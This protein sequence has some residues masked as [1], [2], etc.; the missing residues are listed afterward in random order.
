MARKN[1]ISKREL[2]I[3]KR[4]RAVREQNHLTKVGMADALGIN[5]LRYNNYEYGKVPLPY[6]VAQQLCKQFRVGQC[7]L[8]TGE[9]EM[10]AGVFYDPGV[11][12]SSR[13]PFS[14]AC[15]AYFSR[16]FQVQQAFHKVVDPLTE[17]EK[18]RILGIVS[19]AF[20]LA[21]KEQQQKLV[22]VIER[23]AATLFGDDREIVAQLVSNERMTTAVT[24]SGEDFGGSRLVRSSFETMERRLIAKL[25]SKI[26][27]KDSDVGIPSARLIPNSV[28]E[29]L[30]RARAFY[31][32]HATGIE[33]ARQCRV[34]PSRVSEWFAEKVQPSGDATLRLLQWVEEREGQNKTPG[35]ATNTA[36]SKETR[37]RKPSQNENSSSGRRK[38]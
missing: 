14:A 35:S 6:S 16:F 7:W 4:L 12:L 29:L 9:T 28:A 5:V 3:A 11:T 26:V 22:D 32:E 38:K 20:S 37:K 24:S 1:P 34:S 23:A 17:K 27:D 25:Q 30:G 2:E 10:R 13:I 21:T 15:D 19:N 8:A 33:I 31:P 36:G 18:D